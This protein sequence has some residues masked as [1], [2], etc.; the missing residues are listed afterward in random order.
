MRYRFWS[1][2]SGLF[3]LLVLV[4]ALPMGARADYVYTFSGSN[5]ASPG[6]NNTFSFTEPSLI[7]TTGSFT[8]STVV[9]GTAFPDS[10]FNATTDCFAF[11][12][13][14]ISAC[15][16]LPMF[17]EFFANFPG[18]TAVGTYSPNGE[19]CASTTPQ[20]CEI[21]NSLTI[22]ATPEPSSLMLLGTGL[23]GFAGVVKRRLS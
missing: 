15:G 4:L 18:A 9:A 22:A 3:A 6:G 12:V 16:G 17:G 23:L 2:A 20:P 5:F 11:A 1:G 10:Y 7:T 13:S 8:T 19:G 14:P 21:L